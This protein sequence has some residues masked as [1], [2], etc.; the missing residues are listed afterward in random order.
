MKLLVVTSPYFMAASEYLDN[1]Q[2]TENTAPIL[3][4]FVKGKMLGDAAAVFRRWKNTKVEVRIV[5]D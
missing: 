5:R 3:R 2:P 4:K 1:G